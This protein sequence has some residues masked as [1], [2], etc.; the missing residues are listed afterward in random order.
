MT[1]DPILAQGI[2]VA[3]EGAAATRAAVQK[4]CKVSDPRSNLAFDPYRT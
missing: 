1:I 3:M 4:S 2:T